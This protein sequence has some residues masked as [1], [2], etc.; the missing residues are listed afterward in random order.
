MNREVNCETANIGKTVT[1]AGQQIEDIRLIEEHMG[2]DA[3]PE[4]LRQIAE[5]RLGHPEASLQ[6]LGEL[7]APPVGKSGVNHRLRRLA[8]IAAKIREGGEA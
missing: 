7:L 3:L 8:E 1:A 4:S 5:V 6:A 2:F